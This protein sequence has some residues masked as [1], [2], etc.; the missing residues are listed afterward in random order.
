MGIMNLYV[1]FSWGEIVVKEEPGLA[2]ELDTEEIVKDM[3]PDQAGEEDPSSEDVVLVSFED[4]DCEAGESIFHETKS[5]STLPAA[6][7]TTADLDLAVG[8]SGSSVFCLVPRGA[9]QHEE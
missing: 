7:C 2:G 6:C 4:K 3:N 5:P 9:I 8:S 1:L